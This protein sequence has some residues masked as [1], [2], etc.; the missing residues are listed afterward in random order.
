M[1]TEKTY[2]S[3]YQLAKEFIPNYKTKCAT[4]LA[5]QFVNDLNALS[6]ITESLNLQIN[7]GDSSPF[8]H[9]DIYGN[10]WFKRFNLGDWLVVCEGSNKPLIIAD[11]EFHK[12]YEEIR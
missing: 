11:S 12:L 9:G 2:D 4:I 5:F 8:N 3:A 10:G 7:I 1:K 6:V